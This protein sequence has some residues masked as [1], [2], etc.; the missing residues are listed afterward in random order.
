VYRQLSNRHSAAGGFTVEGAVN[1]LGSYADLQYK[2]GESS[3]ALLY[4]SFT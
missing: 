3:C 4:M 1:L 2:D